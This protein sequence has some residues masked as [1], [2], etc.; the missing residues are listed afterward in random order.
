MFDC[1]HGGHI[2]NN[3]I[4]GK[5][6]CVTHGKELR[7]HSPESLIGKITSFGPWVTHG[8]ELSAFTV[9]SQPIVMNVQRFTSETREVI[10]YLYKVILP[11]YM[12]NFYVRCEVITGYPYGDALSECKC[13]S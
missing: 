10:L 8:V 9:I 4:Q 12:A 3:V 1:D 2:E 5:M 6:P 13:D 11:V 7:Y